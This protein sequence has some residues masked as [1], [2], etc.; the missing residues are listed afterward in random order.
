MLLLVV[1]RK[2]VINGKNV[3]GDDEV[4]GRWVEWPEVG[5]EDHDAEG[6]V[7]VI[8]VLLHTLLELISKILTETHV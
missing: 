5:T 2:S 8:M 7:H 4:T 6:N 1:L 3:S